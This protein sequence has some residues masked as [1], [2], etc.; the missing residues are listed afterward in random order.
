MVKR[1]WNNVKCKDNLV[2]DWMCFYDSLMEVADRFRHYYIKGNN[3]SEKCLIFVNKIRLQ[4]YNII[5]KPHFSY[6]NTV[7]FVAGMGHRTHCKLWW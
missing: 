6:C 3:F 4:I 5:V 2:C 1:K 7:I